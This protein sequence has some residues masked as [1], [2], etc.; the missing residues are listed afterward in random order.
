MFHNPSIHGTV[1]FENVMEMILE[2]MNDDRDKGYEIMI[3]TDSQPH[4][5]YTLYVETIAVHR[6]GKGGRYFY[7]KTKVDSKIEFKNRIF[8]ETGLSLQLANHITEYLTQNVYDLFV[9]NPRIDLSI[10]VDAGKKGKTR[11]IL[12]AITGMVVG[13]GFQCR[14]KPDSFVASTIAD[15]HTK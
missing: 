8:T 13:S 7:R 14:S 4:K 12:S 9:E 5:H 6:E 1:G 11:E 10:H 2:F 15:K 3:G